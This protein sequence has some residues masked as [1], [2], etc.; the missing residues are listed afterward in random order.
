MTRHKEPRNGLL[1][2]VA[3]I[4]VGFIAAAYICFLAPPIPADAQGVGFFGTAATGTRTSCS[5]IT[6]PVAGQTVCFE[7]SENLWK[8]WTGV[9]WA[10]TPINVVAGGLPTGENLI[11]YGGNSSDGPFLVASSSTV[12]IGTEITSGITHP[13]LGLSNN[14]YVYGLSI[15]GASHVPIIGLNTGDVVT[16]APSATATSVG[17]ALLVGHATASVGNAGQI[18]M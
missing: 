7:Q 2:L 9:Q 8:R 1:I 18:I 5:A 3:G 6:N 15:G 11:V 16:I 13:A 4:V 14:R 10:M 17:G 12:L